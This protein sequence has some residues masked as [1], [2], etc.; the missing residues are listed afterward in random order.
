MRTVACRLEISAT[1]TALID[2]THFSAPLNPYS[3]PY[4]PLITPQLINYGLGKKEKKGL[5]PVNEVPRNGLTRGPYIGFLFH[6]CTDLGSIFGLP[7]RNIWSVRSPHG[8]STRS[9]FCKQ[10]RDGHPALHTIVRSK[11]QLAEE[12]Q[13]RPTYLGHGSEEAK[14][15]KSLRSK[16]CHPIEKGMAPILT[17]GTALES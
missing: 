3:D 7:T 10:V 5:A 9:T 17:F 1:R 4:L 14:L 13:T 2:H 15:T 8:L 16:E 11:S 6:K 12:T